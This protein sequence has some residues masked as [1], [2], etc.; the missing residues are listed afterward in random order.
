LKNISFFNG[1]L[2]EISMEKSKEKCPTCG[3]KVKF[4]KKHIK[5]M[6]SSVE[7]PGKSPGNFQENSKENSKEKPKNSF[8]KEI[9]LQ[10]EFRNMNEVVN[11]KQEKKEYECGACHQKFGEKY[12]RCPHCGVEFE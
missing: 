6:H 12:K 1:K 10:E 5:K 11:P 9:N 8:L 2:M 4:L 3:K 7:N